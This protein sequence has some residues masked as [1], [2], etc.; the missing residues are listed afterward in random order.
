MTTGIVRRV[1]DGGFGFISREGGADLFFHNSDVVGKKALITDD[2]VSFVLGIQTKGTKKGQPCAK[3]VQLLGQSG[4]EADWF[5]AVMRDDVSLIHRMASDGQDVNALDRDINICNRCNGSG[6]G[7]GGYS[8]KDIQVSRR[9]WICGECEGNKRVATLQSAVDKAIAHTKPNSLGALISLKAHVNQKH[10]ELAALSN[11]TAIVKMLIDAGVDPNIRVAMHEYDEDEYCDYIEC[12]PIEHSNKLSAETKRLFIECKSQVVAL[13]LIVLAKEQGS[14]ELSFTYASGR[15]AV[16]A[17]EF[18]LDEPPSCIWQHV[19]DSAEKP[20]HVWMIR[21][22][23]LQMI[24]PDGR[25]VSRRSS[26]EIRS[27]K[28][29]LWPDGCAA[30]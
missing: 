19:A 3:Q 6:Q 30:D 7:Q 26:V 4:R 9:V 27:L 2:R 23:N 1:C 8:G 28:D 10:L 16:P 24:L 17:K 18:L 25:S 14:V 5:D 12:V 15:L 22:G 13:S 20:S 11:S 21:A 29:L